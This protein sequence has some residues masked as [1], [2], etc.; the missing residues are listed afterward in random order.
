VNTYY[1]E[2][3]SAFASQGLLSMVLCW[4]L[5]I[6]QPSGR[7]RL[8]SRIDG[9]AK[10]G[11]WAR[12]NR[13]AL[14][15]EH[16]EWLCYPRRGQLCKKRRCGLPHKAYIV[17]PLYVLVILRARRAAQDLGGMFSHFAAPLVLPWVARLR[18]V[19]AAFG[20]S[21]TADVRCATTHSEQALSSV[22]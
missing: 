19:H 12:Q 11:E 9:P 8:G 20:S 22:S 2:P 15:S 7:C 3:A 21:T 16:N 1:V 6:C 5:A 14:K 18:T 4:G 10:S 17:G 13:K